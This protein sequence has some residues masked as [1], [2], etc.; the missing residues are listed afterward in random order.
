[1]NIPR[2]SLSRVGRLRLFMSGWIVVMMLLLTL[3]A[4]TGCEVISSLVEG[5]AK[6]NFA[7]NS[8]KGYGI[9]NCKGEWLMEPI[10]KDKG[11]LYGPMSDGWVLIYFSDKNYYNFINKDGQLLNTERYAAAMPFS[12]GLAA[13]WVDEEWGFIDTKGEYAITPRYL[14]GI[15]GSFSEGLA[16]VGIETD[17]KVIASSW[18]FV[19]KKGQQVLGPYKIAG[20][21]YDGYAQ[22][23]THGE[24]ENFHTGFINKKGDFVLEFSDEDDLGPVTQYGEG[25]F[26]VTDIKEQTTKGTCSK[27][28]MDIKGQWV[29]EP[30]YCEIVPFNNGV[31]PVTTSIERPYVW[32]VI[33][34]Q[35]DLVVPEEYDYIDAF[36]GGCARVFWD[37]YHSTGL[38]DTKG[39][40]IY[41][42]EQEKQ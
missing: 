3:P 20:P 26:P 19:D 33:N 28:Y 41:V 30:D 18:I 16:N 34:K 8:D 6:A 14:G 31:A 38:I 17:S 9:M 23:V 42:Y 21:F 4:L 15:I 25:M 2:A 13:V 35:G 40:L 1:M 10:G 22:V 29:I 11:I 39:E 36:Y 32:G 7:M 27:G 12:E 5:E 24:N 37:D